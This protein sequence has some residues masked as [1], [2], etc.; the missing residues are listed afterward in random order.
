[1]KKIILETPLGKIRGLETEDGIQRFTG[2]RYAFAG[3]WEYPQQAGAW[4]E[5]RK[6]ENYRYSEDC[7]FLNIWKPAVCR[8][9]PV[10][11]YIH[12]ALFRGAA[13]TKSI[14]AVRHM[15]ERELLLYGRNLGVLEKSLS[16]MMKPNHGNEIRSADRADTE[17]PAALFRFCT[18]SG[19]LPE[20]YR[21][22]SGKSGKSNWSLR[23]RPEN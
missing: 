9:A 4:K 2:V 18:V 11:L 3:R 10:I 23:F 17:N 14:S 22:F 5:F 6:G 20:S 7:F 1:M 19:I 13:E 15:P 12:G 16:W 8:E 21:R